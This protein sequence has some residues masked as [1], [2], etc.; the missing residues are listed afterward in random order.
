MDIEINIEDDRHF[1]DVASIVDREDFGKEIQRLRS[2]L[3]IKLP[4]TDTDFPKEDEL[5]REIEVSRKNLFLSVTFKSIL[6]AVVFR[7]RITDK[8]YS[9]VYLDKLQNGTF[10]KEGRTP[11]D[12]Y[13]IVL[14]PEARDEDVIKALQQY[15]DQLGNVK[16]SKDYR[17]I[18]QV[19]EKNKQKPSIKKYRKWYMDRKKDI[20]FADIALSETEHCLIKETHPTGKNK[21][22]GCTCYDESTIRKGVEIYESLIWK[23]R[24]F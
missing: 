24:T 14:S 23:T 18:H 11:D 1:I 22:K 6:E 8:D 21:P 20:S 3:R 16:G 15:R 9:P 2:V 19:W 4:L 13:F 10:D 5:E 12:T 17:Y 7:N